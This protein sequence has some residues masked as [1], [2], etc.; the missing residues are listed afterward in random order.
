MREL[1]LPDYQK[2][3][4]LLLQI[5][6]LSNVNCRKIMEVIRKKGEVNITDI[7]TQLGIEQ[8][9]ASQFLAQLRRFNIVYTRREGKQVF[10][11]LDEDYIKKAT[12]L[13]T[14]FGEK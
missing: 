7:Y 13:I 4:N 9:V 10:Y 11:S 2:T 6:L 12:E 8:S 3:R 5:R 1:A 14:E